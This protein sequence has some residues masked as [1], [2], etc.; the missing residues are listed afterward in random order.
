MNLYVYY[1]YIH[2]SEKKFSSFIKISILY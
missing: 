1:I 2:I